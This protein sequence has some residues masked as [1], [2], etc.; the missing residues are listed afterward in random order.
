DNPDKDKMRYRISYQLIGTSEWYDLLKPGELLT[1]ESYTWET[2][3]MPEGRYRIRIYASDELSNPPKQAKQH[4]LES[5]VV[6]VDNTPPNIEQLRV[7]G[8]VIQGVVIDGVGPVQRIE[9]SIA[10]SEEWYPFH[11]DDG[12]FDEQREEFTADIGAFAPPGTQL[13]SVRAYDSANNFV[14]KHLS[15]R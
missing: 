11:P 6:L 14:V 5:G 12:I 4:R 1:T 7:N 9:V 13:V 3:D 10:G 2:A 8:R 15:V